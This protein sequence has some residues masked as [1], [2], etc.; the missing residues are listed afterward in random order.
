VIE[1]YRSGEKPVKGDKVRMHDQNDDLLGKDGG[2]LIGK[3]GIVQHPGSENV[4]FGVDIEGGYYPT[5]ASRFDLLDRPL[6]HGM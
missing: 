2:H 6:F 4:A 1:N 3:Q 5:R